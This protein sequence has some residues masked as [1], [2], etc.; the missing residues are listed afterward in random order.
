MLA[1][2][3]MELLLI[4]KVVVHVIAGAQIVKWSGLCLVCLVEEQD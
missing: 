4:P 1:S 3:F 2:K